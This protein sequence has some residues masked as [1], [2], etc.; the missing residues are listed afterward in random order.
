MPT[1]RTIARHLGPLGVVVGCEPGDYIAKD[2]AILLGEVVTVEERGGTTVRRASTSA[3]TSTARTSS[4]G[5][6]RRSSSAA[7]PDAPR[8]EVVTVAGHINEA[9]DMF[10]EDYP[11]AAGR[12]GRHRGLLNAG[13][14]HQAMSSTHCLRPV[15]GRVFLRR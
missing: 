11:M 13:G 1:P 10:A 14:Y 7:R 8:T 4:T 15:A 5:S 12:G 6:R 3:G 2:A 9:S